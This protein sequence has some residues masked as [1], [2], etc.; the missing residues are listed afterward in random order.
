A[1]AREAKHLG[2]KR[3]PL[4]LQ[5]IEDLRT[6]HLHEFVVVAIEQALVTGAADEHAQEDLPRGRAMIPL[7]R[8]ERAREKRP[9]FAARN[10]KAER[11]ER[12]AN[13]ELAIRKEDRGRRR[14]AERR[15]HLGE[16]RIEA[17]YDRSGDPAGNGERDIVGV[18]GPI[19]R[20]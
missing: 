19:A 8:D 12:M 7:A 6:G 14:V 11:I 17:V 18:E 10:E 15:A 4:D 5:E 20:L 1:R 16:R 3:R 13:V 2:E 9:A